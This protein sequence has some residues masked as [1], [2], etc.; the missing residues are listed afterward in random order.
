M[1]I[2]VLHD[3]SSKI[4]EHARNQMV[5]P[6]IFRIM[7]CSLTIT[8]LNP[9][10]N[11]RILEV[12]CGSS[13]FPSR[14]SKYYQSEIEVFDAYYAISSIENIPNVVNTKAPK[15]LMR[16]LNPYGTIVKGLPFLSQYMDLENSTDYG[17]LF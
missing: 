17:G 3:E 8:L 4:A 13:I 9:K 2:N 14:V 7:E 16:I 15:E 12:G 11:E 1:K 6:N 5:D 10:Q